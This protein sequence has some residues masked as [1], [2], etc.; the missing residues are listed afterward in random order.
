MPTSPKGGRCPFH[1]VTQGS[2]AAGRADV[3]FA[4]IA[5]YPALPAS[6]R[7]SSAMKSTNARIRVDI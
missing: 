2:T 3:T 1:L 6:L 7:R 5:A 4:C